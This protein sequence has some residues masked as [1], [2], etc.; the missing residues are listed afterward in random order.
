MLL[1]LAN[2][3]FPLR[4]LTLIRNFRIANSNSSGKTRPFTISRDF[5]FNYYFNLPPGTGA[6]WSRHWRRISIRRW[7]QDGSAANPRRA[8]PGGMKNRSILICNPLVGILQKK[9]EAGFLIFGEP[10]SRVRQKNRTFHPVSGKAIP[11]S[12]PLIFHVP[13]S[14]FLFS[15]GHISPQ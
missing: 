4:G 5:S 9:Q 3:I 13:Q 6:A 10:T 11:V 12:E 15:A 7:W 2:N 14:V 8:R 1:T